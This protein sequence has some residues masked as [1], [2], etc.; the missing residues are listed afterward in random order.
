M[1][2][3]KRVLIKH[4]VYARECEELLGLQTKRSGMA[5]HLGKCRFCF[6]IWTKVY[7]RYLG[8]RQFANVL[9]QAGHV[10]MSRNGVAQVTVLCI[11]VKMAG[12]R[13][14]DDVDHSLRHTRDKL[15]GDQSSHHLHC[16][17]RM[18]QAGMIGGRKAIRCKA[19]LL[20]ASQP[21]KHRRLKQSPDQVSAASNIV[22]KLNWPVKRV[23]Y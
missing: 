22:F 16:S 6:C 12:E 10:H 15:L 13:L 11:S 18:S 4:I 7:V 1:L 20:D 5:N 9:K 17:Q 21:R 14:L 23:D 3:E 8:E 2:L 19:E